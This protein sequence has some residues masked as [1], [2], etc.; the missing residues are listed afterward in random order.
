MIF[1]NGVEYLS[2]P[3]IQ[4]TVD[5]GT[6]LTMPAFS[7]G[8]ISLGANKLKT[9]NLVLKQISSSRFGIVDAANEASERDLQAET[10][11]A[12]DVAFS[13]Q[14][15]GTGS[16]T[17]I[18]AHDADN[19]YLAL[20]ARDNTVGLIEIARMQGAADP[21]FSM[22]GS[23]EFKFYYSGVATFGAVTLAGAIVGGGQV[24]SALDRQNYNETNLLEN[25]NFEVGD[26]P[27]D[28]T[29]IGG[30]ATVSRSSTQ[31]KIGTYS[32]LLT[33]NG[34]DC[35]I[36]QAYS[37]YAAYAGKTVTLGCWVY[38]TV[39]ARVGIGLGDGVGSASSTSHTGVAGWEWLTTSLTVDASPTYLRSYLE[40]FDGDTSAYFD[41]AILVEGD[42]CPA[43]SPKP[44]GTYDAITLRQKLTA[45][46]VEIEGSAFD[47][48]GG[49]IDGATI[50]APVLDGTVTNTGA[51]LVFPAHSS[52][53]IS[54]G[55]NAIKTTNIQIIEKDVAY[56]AIRN[57][58]DT[59][60]QY[61]QCKGFQTDIGM[62][63]NLNATYIS[64]RNVN[65]NYVWFR[66]RINGGGW[67]E[68]GRITGAVDP[69]FWLGNAGNA[70][71]STYGGKIGFYGTAAI[72]KQTGVAV[73]AAGI[74]AAL[75]A[76]GLITA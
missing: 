18:S 19:A 47:I 6:G 74:H 50:T 40:V 29:L 70:L 73:D 69:E 48:N 33:R 63:S 76:L 41:G 45:G 68:V 57:S 34:T 27:D 17:Y 15:Y 2:S 22:G 49:T 7:S 67:A 23:Q 58:G 51:A 21:Y 60:Y 53:T 37:G 42:S 24:I 28:W 11:Y 1:Y 39:A 9:T 3:T 55:A 62:F 59:D 43:F 71:K 25:G 26:P 20:Y 36:Y 61:L 10:F 75:V 44:I 32:A 56:I 14:I 12:T 46:A 8:D 64:A 30:G 31:A 16:P 72:A 38:A 13:N 54:I 35:H 65:G 52:G 5:P 66:A 4:G